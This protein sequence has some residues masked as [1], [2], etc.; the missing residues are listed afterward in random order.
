MVSRSSEFCTSQ[1]TLKASFSLYKL[2]SPETMPA[3]TT[4]LSGSSSGLGGD[5]GL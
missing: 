5:I 1:E 4:A 3:S 2:P